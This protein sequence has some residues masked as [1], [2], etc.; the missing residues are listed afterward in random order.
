MRLALVRSRSQ[1]PG[2]HVREILGQ[3]LMDLLVRRKFRINPMTALRSARM[4]LT[5]L[6]AIWPGYDHGLPRCGASRSQRPH[7]TIPK[8]FGYLEKR[9]DYAYSVVE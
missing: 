4:Q 9:D 5:A 8:D 2:R 7:A 6:A 1:K 3:R